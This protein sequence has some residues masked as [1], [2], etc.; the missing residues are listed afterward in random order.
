[1]VH[2]LGRHD[3]FGGF[4]ANLLQECIRPLV[5][6]ARDIAFVRVTAVG[7]L[8]AFNDGRQTR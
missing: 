7:G 8:A 1:M 3:D 6:Q 5:Q 4:L 2:V